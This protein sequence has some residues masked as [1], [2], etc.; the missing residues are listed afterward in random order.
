MYLDELDRCIGAYARAVS[1]LRADEYV[2][3]EALAEILLT[4]ANAVHARHSVTG[5]AGDL[6]RS[7]DLTLEAVHLAGEPVNVAALGPI[8][9]RYVD[10]YRARGRAEDFAA[11][12]RTLRTALATPG[13]GLA[14]RASI[15]LRLG[16]VYAARFTMTAD[17]ADRNRSIETLGAGWREGSGHPPLGLAYVDALL[18]AGRCDPAVATLAAIDIDDLPADLRSNYRALRA[19]A[20]GAG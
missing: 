6:D 12:E 9:D 2:D 17:P 14:E 19:I 15:W 18:E 20:V 7:I 4:Y 13:A 10:R 1:A 5:N 3:P 16:H 11:A 8:S